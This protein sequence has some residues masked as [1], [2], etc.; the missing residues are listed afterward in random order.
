VEEGLPTVVPPACCSG[1]DALS[2]CVPDQPCPG[3]LLFCVDCGDRACDPHENPY[4]CLDDCPE[5]CPVGEERS[6]QC[7]GGTPVDWCACRPPECRPVC[8]YLGT[9]SEG[10]Y[11]SCTGALIEWTFCSD[12]DVAHRSVC[13]HIATDSE[14]WYDEATGELILWDYCAP[15]WDCII[16]PKTQCR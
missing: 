15:L 5:G 12:S 10:W 3:S 7:P 11:D 13:L 9:R 2:D 8:L 14:G 6:Y 1:L 4:N 16:D